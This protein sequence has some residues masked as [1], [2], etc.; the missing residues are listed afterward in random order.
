MQYEKIRCYRCYEFIK[1]EGPN[2]ECIYCKGK[3]PMDIKL[4]L[5]TLK[6][7]LLQR[8]IEYNALN[9]SFKESLDSYRQKIE[10]VIVYK[11]QKV[12]LEMKLSELEKD[13]TEMEDDLNKLNEKMLKCR[14]CNPKPQIEDSDSDNDKKSNK[15]SN[16]KPIRLI[17]KK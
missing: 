9:Q 15:K 5:D 11:M 2:I 1:V 10:N 16:K 4:E 7:K 6:A 14:L 12:E 17:K 3:D 8:D 13:F